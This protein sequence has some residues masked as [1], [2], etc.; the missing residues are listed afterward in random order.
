MHQF[1]WRMI[2]NSTMIHVKACNQE[3]F[4]LE[5]FSW[6]QGTSVNISST[7][8]ENF[9]LETL[10]STFQMR[11]ST[12]DYHNQGIFSKIRTFFPVFEKG[13]GRPTP[14]SYAPDIIH[15]L[16]I[17]DPKIWKILTSHGS[18]PQILGEDLKI[19]DQNNWGGGGG[20][21]SKN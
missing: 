3:F 18:S 19:S 11:N 7:I 16:Y 2:N 4:R 5:E 1:L 12:Q 17:W 21:L 9:L 6:N 10:K 14:S 20:D 15:Y 13:Q 8:H